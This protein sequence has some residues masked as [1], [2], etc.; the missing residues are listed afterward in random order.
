[1]KECVIQ[2]KLRAIRKA[3]GISQEKMAQ[4]LCTDTSNY[5][6]KERGEIRIRDEE[7]QKLSIA[8]GVSI[9]D[10]K[11][12]MEEYS[13]KDDNINSYVTFEDFKHNCD[14]FESVIKNLQEF[15]KNLQA[16]N[17]ELKNKLNKKE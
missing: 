4:I 14:F 9:E 3:K 1:M 2:E 10:I 17:Q 16:E 12:R 5:S 8:L 6:R 13:T 7:W 15:I 11:E